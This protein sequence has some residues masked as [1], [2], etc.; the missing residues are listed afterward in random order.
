MKQTAQPV[1]PQF[2]AGVQGSSLY[3]DDLAPTGVAQ[4][5]WRWYHF[6]ALWVG[7]GD[8]HPVVHARRRPDEEGM[9]PWQAVITVLL[10]NADRAGADAADRPRGRE[11]R[12]S[13]RGAG[14]LVVRHAGRAAAGDAARHRRL[15]LVRH[16]DVVRR[17]RDLHAARHSHRQ[18]A[19]RRGAAVARHLRSASSRASSCSGRCR[20]T[21]SCTASIRSAGSKAGPRRSRS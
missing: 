21:S 19:A 15:R 5:T 20:S 13:V 18:R 9:S 11:V 16:P 14:A 4:R 2:A 6:A 3:N 12:H 1:D 8:V 10:G 17:Q 7:H